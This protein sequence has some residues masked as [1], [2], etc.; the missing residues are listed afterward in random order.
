[1]PNEITNPY[2]VFEALKRHYFMYIN[3]RFALRHP[4][5]AKERQALLDGDR[6]LYREP[7]VEAVAPY[8]YADLTL[9]EAVE[10]WDFPQELPEFADLG[11]FTFPRLYRHQLEAIAA[12]HRGRHVVTTAGTGSGKTESFLIPIVC[13]LLRESRDW[14]VPGE[15]SPTRRWWEL[16]KKYEPQRQHEHRTAAVRAM[17]LYPMNALVEDQMQRLR[18]SL[19]SPHVRQWFQENRDGNRFYFGRYTGQTPV[20]GAR[21]SGAVKLR[22]SLNEIAATAESVRTDASRRN[23]FPRVDGAEMLTR[24]DMQDFPPDILITNYSM[25]NIMLMRDHEED[26]I[27]NTR[28]WLAK[29]RSNVFTLVIDELHMYRGTPGT[30]VAYL[31]R[32]LLLRLGLWERPDQVRFIAAS[33]SLEDDVAG[34]NYI[35]EFFGMDANRFDII[36][37]ERNWSISG[38]AEGQARFMPALARIEAVLEGESAEWSPATETVKLAEM[39]PDQ[40]IVLDDDLLVGEWLRETGLEGAMVW[41]CS[42]DGKAEA[43]SISQLAESIFGQRSDE[44]QRAIE[45]LIALFA[46]AKTVDSV[47][48]ESRPILPIRLHNFF[49]SMLGVYACCDPEC[50]CRRPEVSPGESSRRQA[51]YAAAHSL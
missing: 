16:G 2:G 37:G 34:R 25:L 10:R 32:K 9:S 49:R 4:A 21:K 51:V 23:F 12:N 30:E 40:V 26:I 33:A 28:S 46:R 18:E 6:R 11:L 22:R 35:R 15:P 24:W 5:L 44:A 41:A 50:Q 1:M 31:L 36:P 48:G 27:E 45:G 3:S 7:F 13:Q 42:R 43:R 39:Q 14:P 20:S 17:I 38:D 47:T 29:D 8:E 19:D